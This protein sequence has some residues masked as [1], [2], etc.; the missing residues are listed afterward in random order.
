VA[1]KK[2]MTKIFFHPSLFL[3]FLDPGSG[4][5][6]NQDLGSG[7]NILDPQHC[8]DISD[9]QNVILDKEFYGWTLDELFLLPDLVKSSKNLLVLHDHMYCKEKL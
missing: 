7:I 2:G 5:G 9:F 3:L 8:P 6:K 1:T 4:M